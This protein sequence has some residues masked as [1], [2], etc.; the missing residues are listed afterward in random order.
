MVARDRSVEPYHQPTEELLERCVNEVAFN[1]QAPK[2]LVMSTALAAVSTSLQ[3]IVDI[4]WPDGRISPLSLYF[5]TRAK[6]GER[7]TSV[8]SRIFS[9]IHEFQRQEREHFRKGQDKYFVD[10]E[11]WEKKRKAIMSKIVQDSAKGKEVSDLEGSLRE[12]EK[13]KPVRE[14]SL[15]FLYDDVTSE[16]LIHDMSENSK[17]TAL[18]TSEGGSILRGGAFKN[19]SKINDLWSGETVKSDRKS[20]DSSYVEGGRLTMNIMVQPEVHDSYLQRIGDE[21]RGSGMW[22]RFLVTEPDSMIGTR[23]SHLGNISWS[24][25]ERFARRLTDFLKVTKKVVKGDERRKV[26]RLSCQA[27][28]RFILISNEIEKCT[29]PGGWYQGFEDHASK[30]S[31][32][33]LRVAGVLHVF[34]GGMSTE[35]TLA[36]MEKAIELVL[37]YS[38]QFKRV[39]YVPSEEEIDDQKMKD[40]LEEKRARGFRYLKK[41]YVLKYGPS[42]LR[43]KSRLDPCLHRVSDEGQVSLVMIEG[44]E[45]VDLLPF[46]VFDRINATDVAKAGARGVAKKCI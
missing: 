19:F 43:R 33:I 11:I 44:V 42:K 45:V 40:W 2:E 37:Y 4:Q 8:Y 29:G 41:N 36:S 35:V 28:E 31:E 24:N 27:A 1:I 16:A 32:N 15:N 21:S 13:Q 12:N 23:Y 9:P 25:S 10:Y 7:K 3:G 38:N 18:V 6:S 46:L 26:V 39:F 20:T 30:L 22:A 34:S 14:K 17:Y 5:L